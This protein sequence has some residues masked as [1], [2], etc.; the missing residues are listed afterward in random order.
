MFVGEESPHIEA[1]ALFIRFGV[2]GSPAN[3]LDPNQTKAAPR[4]FMCLLERKHL[5]CRM[6]DNGAERSTPKRHK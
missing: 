2:L 4:F 5:D 1:W 3:P 6:N